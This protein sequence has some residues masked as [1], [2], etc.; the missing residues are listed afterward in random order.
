MMTLESPE[1][2]PETAE[3]AQLAG[4]QSLMKDFTSCISCNEEDT[5]I[6]SL[7]PGGFDCSLKLIP[8][9]L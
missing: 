9:N 4:K 6:N 3:V 8:S 5:R 7:A 2:Q 1:G